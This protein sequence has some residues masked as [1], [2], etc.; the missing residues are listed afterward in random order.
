MELVVGSCSPLGA[1]SFIQL[2]AWSSLELCC[3]A[4]RCLTVR[5]RDEAEIQHTVGNEVDF[6]ICVCCLGNLCLLERGER[7]RPADGMVGW[8]SG[9]VGQA[10]VCVGGT[11]EF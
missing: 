6:L 2:V 7:E 4:T 3:A 8:D 10:C 11:R 1:A 5:E 9:L